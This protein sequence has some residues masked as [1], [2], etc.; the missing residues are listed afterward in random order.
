MN[1]KAI[2]VEAL[3]QGLVFRFQGS[4]LEIGNIPLGYYLNC[5]H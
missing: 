2:A 1:L 5:F 3:V 4:G